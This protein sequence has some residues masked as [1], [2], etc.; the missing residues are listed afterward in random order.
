M[1]LGWEEVTYGFSPQ[2][3]QK[4]ITSKFWAIISTSLFL[5]ILKFWS[6][7]LLLLS[8]F[9]AQSAWCL[10]ARQCFSSFIIACSVSQNFSTTQPPTS[11]V[12]F[13]DNLFPLFRV[14][15]QSTFIQEL[16][17]PFSDLCEII[18]FPT[19]SFLS[20]LFYPF[21]QPH[22]LNDCTDDGESVMPMMVISMLTSY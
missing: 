6:N 3:C 16:I 20:F 4:V 22:L 2:Q 14:V 7:A 11:V 12:F 18:I 13:F 9:Q 15:W 5:E 8:P 21:L 1:E 10:Q 17:S 19:V